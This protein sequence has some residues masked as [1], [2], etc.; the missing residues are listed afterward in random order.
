LWRDRFL[1][2]SVHHILAQSGPG[3]QEAQ[4]AGSVQAGH[5]DHGGLQ[6]L[7]V[8]LSA[9]LLQTLAQL[10]DHRRVAL[11][12]CQFASRYAQIGDTGLEDDVGDC[13]NEQRAEAVA[14]QVDE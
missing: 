2:L 8:D 4:S 1:Y 12:S 10:T 13:A 11:A 6:A 5:Y 3:Q 9:D 7:R 14:N